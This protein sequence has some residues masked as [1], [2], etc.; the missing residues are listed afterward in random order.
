[1]SMRVFGWEDNPSID[2]CRFKQS[3]NRATEIVSSGRGS[4]IFLP[5]G[6]KA[7]QLFAVRACRFPLASLDRAAGGTF[8]SAWT[9]KPSGGMPVWQMHS[10]RAELTA[11]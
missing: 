2:R 4:F 9:I 3:L 10:Q 8:A 6:R 5:D 7:V 11:A 1:M